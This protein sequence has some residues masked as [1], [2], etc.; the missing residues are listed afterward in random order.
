MIRRTAL[1]VVVPALVAGCATAPLP[2]P[3]YPASHPA[4]PE[5]L[6][7]PFVRPA[8][9][10]A[11]DFSFPARTGQTRATGNAAMNHEEGVDHAAMGHGPA[12]E[13]SAGE[14]TAMAQAETADAMGTGTVHSVDAGQRTV[15][16]SHDPIPPIGW[17]AMTMDFQVAPSVD[18]SAIEPESRVAFTLT[19]GAD[20]MYV[21]E[22]LRPASGDGGGMPGMDHEQMDHGSMPGMD[23]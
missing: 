14:G 19:R 7:A 1:F 5:A 18:L 6:A 9:V 11:S 21:I 12:G 10:L 3:S 16:V 20:G 2:E 17:P 23:H 13:T 22:S 15:N 8:N 4:S